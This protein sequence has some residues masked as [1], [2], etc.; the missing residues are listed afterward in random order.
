MNSRL[1]G[2]MS[3]IARLPGSVPDPRRWAAGPAPG[4]PNG[5]REL[6]TTQVLKYWLFAP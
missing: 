4:Y 2:S 6:A 1:S 5:C 3:V